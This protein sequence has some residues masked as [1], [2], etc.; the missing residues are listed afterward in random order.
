MIGYVKGT[1]ALA[2]ENKVIV[3]VQ[4]VGYLLSMSM[5]SMGQLPP[6]GSEVKLYTYM[7]VRE[8][9]VSLFGFI[10]REEQ[11]MFERLIT[12]SG[13]GPKAALGILGTLNVNDLKFAI[14]SDDAKGIA[15]APGVGAKTAQRIVMELKDKISL[16]EAFEERT[17]SIGAGAEASQTESD[18]IQGLVA[19]GYGAGE[20]LKAVNSVEND[21]TMTA[22]QLLKAALK[23]LF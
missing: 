11:E 8:D 15:R 23:N 3:D 12:I 20:A 10:N 18:A 17:R 7:Q 13:V 21:G 5:N 4:G 14:L 2:G 16:E 22:E 6:A 9:A 19:L 1:L